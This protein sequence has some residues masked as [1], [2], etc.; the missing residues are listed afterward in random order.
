MLLQGLGLGRWEVGAEG[1]SS[2]VV[3]GGGF[4]ERGE[5]TTSGWT[6][7]CVLYSTA[8]ASPQDGKLPLLLEQEVSV[9]GL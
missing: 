6:L 5:H 9:W 8:H 3:D 1:G 7:A 4:Q 2:M